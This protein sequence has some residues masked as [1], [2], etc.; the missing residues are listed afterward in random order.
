MDKVAENIL[1]QTNDQELEDISI[2]I[3]RHNLE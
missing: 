3:F 2:L 1:R